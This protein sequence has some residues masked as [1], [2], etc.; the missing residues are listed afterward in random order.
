M[1]L[2]IT[3]LCIVLCMN[4]AGLNAQN[5][6]SVEGA[7]IM[8]NGIPWEFTGTDNMAV[9]SLP[10]NYSTQQS[11]GMDIARECIDLKMTTD[12]KLEALVTSARN[13]GHVVILAGF[14]YDSDAFAGGSVSYP[15]CQ[16]LGVNPQQDPRWAVVMNRWKEIANLPFI[17]NK[18]DVWINPWNEPYSWDGSNG[19]TNDLW[20]ADAKAMI[21]SIRS[22]GAENI[23]VIEGSHMGQGHTVIV[24]KGQY[25]REGRNNILFDIHCY[26]SRWNLPANSIKFYFQGLKKSG[27]AFIVGEFAA[28]GEHIW[29]PVLEACRAEKVSVLAWLWGQYTEPFASDFKK[30]CMEPR[31]IPAS[32]SPEHENDQI[33]LFPNP[34]TK[35]ISISGIKSD[36]DL[37]VEI[38]NSMGRLV[39]STKTTSKQNNDIDLSF[40]DKGIYLLNIKQENKLSVKKIMKL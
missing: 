8:K 3:C 17:K 31:N 15:A 23:I 26:N 18:T 40:L 20:E 36:T 28:N 34:F 16:L 6:Y 4:I 5:T 27:N 12:S 38:Y 24:Q 39:L 19:Y 37:S 7:Q 2:P 32:I 33:K 9:F 10:Y 1:K 30:Y 14:W 25:V 11:W 29:K 13:K 22:T 21:D 35:G